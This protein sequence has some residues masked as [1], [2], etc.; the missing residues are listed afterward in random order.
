M[1][2]EESEEVS[3]GLLLFTVY[4]HMKSDCRSNKDAR[5]EVV[6]SAVSDI[7]A[8]FPPLQDLEISRH[9]SMMF[10]H[11]ALSWFPVIYLGTSVW[12]HVY[13][14][15]Q[16]HTFIVSALPPPPPLHHHHRTILLQIRLHQSWSV[17]GPCRTVSGRPCSVCGEVQVQR[18][19]N[20]WRSDWP[21]LQSESFSIWRFRIQTKINLDLD[22]IQHGLIRSTTLP[23]SAYFG[24][25]CPDVRTGASLVP[26][27]P[28]GSA[29]LDCLR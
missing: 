2:P 9:I 8:S 21:D 26:E 10:V 12:Y 28:H 5:K 19:I 23:R 7:N 27:S 13:P 11:S 20:Y 29:L 17:L 18:K 16:K 3:P 1:F 6:F 22:R 25:R 14:R 4:R 24:E 15:A